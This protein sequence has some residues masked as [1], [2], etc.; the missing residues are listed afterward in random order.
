MNAHP[1]MKVQMEGRGNT[2][3]HVFVDVV[4][5]IHQYCKEFNKSWVQNL[6][7]FVVVV[8]MGIPAHLTENQNLIL[9]FGGNKQKCIP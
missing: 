2:I 9:A 1:T 3:V 5:P 7:A 6:F 4:E 8:V